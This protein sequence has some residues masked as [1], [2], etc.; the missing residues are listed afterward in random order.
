MELILN[1]PELTDHEVRRLADLVADAASRLKANSHGLG[2]NH[3]DGELLWKLHRAIERTP[4]WMSGCAP[5][6]AELAAPL[7]ESQKEAKR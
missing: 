1:L 2:M 7:A 4:E 6:S 5:T 3:F